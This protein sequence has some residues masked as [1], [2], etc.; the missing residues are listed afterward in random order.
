M[1]PVL[2][3]EPFLVPN[4]GIEDG[5]VWLHSSISGGF[6]HILVAVVYNIQVGLHVDPIGRDYPIGI[7]VLCPDC[8]HVL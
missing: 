2:S 4:N 7:Y 5:I 3:S 8:E 6:V 1:C